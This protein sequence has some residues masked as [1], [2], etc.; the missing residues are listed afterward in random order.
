MFSELKA[1]RRQRLIAANQHYHASCI[2]GCG[3]ADLCRHADREPSFEP[4][5]LAET[6]FLDSMYVLRKYSQLLSEK[7]AKQARQALIDACPFG[8]PLTPTPPPSSSSDRAKK[9]STRSSVQS[10]G[11]L[12]PHKTPSSQPVSVVV[13]VASPPRAPAGQLSSRRTLRQLYKVDKSR[14]FRRASTST[15]LTRHAMKLRSNPSGTF[16]ELPQSGRPP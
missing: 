6:H 7:E 3:D 13:A 9:P 8:A 16:C 11:N 14:A 5:E 12:S 2:C 15:K 4:R 1:E 10:L